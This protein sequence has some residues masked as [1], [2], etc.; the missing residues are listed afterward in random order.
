VKN[1]KPK[2]P[3]AFPFVLDELSELAPLVRPMFGCHAVYVHDKLV[4]ILRERESHPDDNGVWVAVRE[5]NH[6]R[7]AKEFPSMRSIGLFG[8]GPTGWQVIPADSN[9][10]EEDVVQI[11]RYVLKRDPGIGSI[12]KAKRP[13][14]AKRKART[15]LRRS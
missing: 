8:P 6:E 3:I 13:K 7:F 4:L 9:S 11:C 1:K 12:P 10:F 15:A 14:K 5:G 2:V